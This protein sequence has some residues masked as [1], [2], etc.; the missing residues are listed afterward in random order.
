M[1]RAVGQLK[2]HVSSG[3]MSHR[4]ARGKALNPEAGRITTQSNTAT[5]LTGAI[6]MRR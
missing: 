4:L 3:A 6:H 2:Y 1:E 5:P